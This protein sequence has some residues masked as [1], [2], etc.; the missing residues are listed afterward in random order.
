MRICIDALGLPSFGGTRR[1]VSCLLAEVAKQDHHNHYTIYLYKPEPELRSH[2][3]FIVNIVPIKSRLLLRL[4]AQLNFPLHLRQQ[5][6]MVF[7]AMKNQGIIGVPCRYLL[8]IFDLTHVH[9]SHIYPSLDTLYWRYGLPV[10]LRGV[11]SVMTISQVMTELLN[12]IYHLPFERIRLI[13]PGVKESFF[14]PPSVQQITKVR[15]QYKLT[16][17]LIVYVG[18]WGKHKNL[19]TL[20][21][22]FHLIQD[23]IPHHLLIVGGLYH[24]TNDTGLPVIVRELGLTKR[25]HFL[26]EV[27]DEDLPVLYSLSELFV[28]PSL[29]EGFGLVL[30]EAMARGIPILAT[31][32]KVIA[33]VCSDAAVLVDY[34]L[35]VE[36]WADA[37][38]AILNDSDKRAKLSRLG[39]ARARD[40][41]WE[42]SAT[43]LIQ[44]YMDQ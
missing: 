4:W 32:H 18:S 34:P 2:K 38:P 3:N 37:I 30:V 22:A 42:R 5:K 43:E 16:Q 1:V 6:T 23:R 9:L 25:V 28:F 14:Y 11:D 20:V 10:I 24:T 21:N 41:S 40:F 15:N 19:R 33:E 7:H 12:A 8:S 35:Q 39:H 31:N 27:P 44:W 29:S 26:Q 13:R 17:P 36:V